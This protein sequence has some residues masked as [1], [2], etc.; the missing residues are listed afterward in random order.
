MPPVLEKYAFVVLIVLTSLFSFPV[1]DVSAQVEA[2]DT[3]VLVEPRSAF[4]SGLIEYFVPTVG[5]AYAGNW[6]KGLL[7]NAV[8]TAGFIA[9]VS[10]DDSVD[11]CEAVCV[12]GAVAAVGGTIWAIFGAQR[13]AKRRERGPRPL[14]DRVFLESGPLGGVTVGF[15]WRP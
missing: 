13:T 8:R 2:A 3:V 6:K 7:P 9:A 5:Y 14:E 11:D 15:R 12:A 10:A 1:S 4:L